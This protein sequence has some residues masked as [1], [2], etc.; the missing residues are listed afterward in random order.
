MS[1][2]KLIPN[3][4]NHRKEL[5]SIK[6]IDF[7]YKQILQII[8]PNDRNKYITVSVMMID[9]IKEISNH[10]QYIESH[11]DLEKTSYYDYIKTKLENKSL[12]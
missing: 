2:Y 11:P 9:I 4:A 1:N 8:S 7:A 3:I 6:K 5:S 12:I 10:Y